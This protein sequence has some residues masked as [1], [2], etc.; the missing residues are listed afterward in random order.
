MVI[1][2][3]W[4]I[5]WLVGWL[6]GLAGLRLGTYCDCWQCPP[7]GAAPPAPPGPLWTCTA[8][9]PPPPPAPAPAP[10]AP[11]PT[12]GCPRAAAAAGGVASTKFMPPPVGL[13]WWTTIVVNDCACFL[14]TVSTNGTFLSTSS[15]SLSLCFGSP[16]ASSR[17]HSMR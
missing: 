2:R 7:P 17:C 12:T 3:L 5:G 16:T 15:I 6:V 13:G 10:P 8:P 4:L 9:P 1:S 11:A 14:L